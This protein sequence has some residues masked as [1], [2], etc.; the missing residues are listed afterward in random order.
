MNPLIEEFRANLSYLNYQG[1]G[2]RASD[3]LKKVNKTLGTTHG[4]KLVQF[5]RSSVDEYYDNYE[6][7]LVGDT[8]KLI[9]ALRQAKEEKLLAELKE[10]ASE[11]R[12]QKVLRKVPSKGR[13]GDSLQIIAVIPK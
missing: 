6:W 4:T 2:A 5:V 10:V 9:S 13:Y 1:F 11:V 3:L 12:K 7:A 8:R